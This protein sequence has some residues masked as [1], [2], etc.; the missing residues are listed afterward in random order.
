M[1]DMMDVLMLAILIGLIPV[2]ITIALGELSRM[3]RKRAAFRRHNPKTQELIG[4]RRLH[5]SKR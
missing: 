5:I 2:V 3:N 4:M 1:G